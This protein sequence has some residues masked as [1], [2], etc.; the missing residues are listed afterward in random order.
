M[1][2]RVRAV[3]FLDGFIADHSSGGVATLSDRHVR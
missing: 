1:R 3:V 2:E